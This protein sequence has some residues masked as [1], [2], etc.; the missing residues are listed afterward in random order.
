MNN[1]GT[2]VSSCSKTER[3]AVVVTGV[4]VEKILDVSAIESGTGWAQAKVFL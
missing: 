1:F 3:H 2:D 4:E